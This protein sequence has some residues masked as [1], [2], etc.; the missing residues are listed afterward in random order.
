V[1]KVDSNIFLVKSKYDFNF[2]RIVIIIIII[3][4]TWWIYYRRVLD[5]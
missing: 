5:S 3:Y 2:I 1:Q 4:V